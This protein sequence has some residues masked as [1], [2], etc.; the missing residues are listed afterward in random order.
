MNYFWIELT[1]NWFEFAAVF[2]CVGP[3]REG[4]AIIIITIIIIIIAIMI[5]TFFNM[6]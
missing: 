1:L 4:I 3:G 6:R 2:V 5:I